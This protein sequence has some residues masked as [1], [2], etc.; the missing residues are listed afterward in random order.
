MQNLG[1]IKKMKIAQEGPM[2]T[3]KTFCSSGVICVCMRVQCTYMCLYISIFGI[4]FQ[5]VQNLGVMKKIKV[6]E[7]GPMYTHN[8]FCTY[9]VICSCMQAQCA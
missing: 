5:T 7:E 2:L 9:G 4:S 8:D 1:V 3:H 6:A